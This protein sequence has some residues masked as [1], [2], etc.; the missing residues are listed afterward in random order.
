MAKVGY[1]ICIV[2]WLKKLF[3][4][5]KKKGKLRRVGFSRITILLDLR[6]VTLRGSQNPAPWS[7]ARTK[8][9]SA[10][11]SP[12]N[13]KEVFMR[14]QSYPY[15]RIVIKRRQKQGIWDDPNILSE[16]SKKHETD[17]EE[18]RG[19]PKPYATLNRCLT[20]LWSSTTLRSVSMVFRIPMAVTALSSLPSS[21]GPVWITWLNV[22]ACNEEYIIKWVPWWLSG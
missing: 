2:P 17:D 16:P 11:P 9:T 18:W 6:K 13:S 22:I 14:Y 4:I 20:S 19:T 15:K 10:L 7:K 3:F 1:V 8:Q 5:K 12:S 21:S